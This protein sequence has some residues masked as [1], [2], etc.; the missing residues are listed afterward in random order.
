M[1]E[2]YYGRYYSDLV[3][4]TI[5]SFEGMCGYDE[6]FGGK[7][8]PTFKVRFKTGEIGEIQ[9]SQ[10]EEGNGGGFIFGL[11]VPATT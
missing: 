7:P 5:L 11:A 1:S 3:G 10:D 8:F 9:I 4:A 2:E 6:E